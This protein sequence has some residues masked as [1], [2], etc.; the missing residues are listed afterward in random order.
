[1]GTRIE[2]NESGGTCSPTNGLLM[3]VNV[4]GEMA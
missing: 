1:M 3:N 2:S 4:Q